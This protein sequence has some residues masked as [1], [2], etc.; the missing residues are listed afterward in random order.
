MINVNSVIRCRLAGLVVVGFVGLAGVIAAAAQGLV[1]ITICCPN[2]FVRVD[3]ATGV[4]TPLSNVGDETFGFTSSP[5]VDA[6]THSFYIVRSS[7]TGSQHRVVTINTQTGALVE[8]PPLAQGIFALGFDPSLAPPPTV[9]TLSFPML[10]LLAL[11]LAGAAL[12]LIKR[13]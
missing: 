10:T 4:L 6:A 8:S 9:P 1:G 3:A 5:A 12:F 11:A 2:Q 7:T 13:P